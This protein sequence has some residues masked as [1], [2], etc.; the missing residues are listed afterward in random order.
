VDWNNG[1]ALRPAVQQNDRRTMPRPPDVVQPNIA[2]IGK[3]CVNESGM[4][5]LT[6]TPPR[7]VRPNV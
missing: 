2:E 6:L 4:A 7:A 1:P 3:A 5:I